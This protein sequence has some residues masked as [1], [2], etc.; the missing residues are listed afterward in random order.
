[1]D[2]E[3]YYIK[4]RNLKMYKTILSITLLLF[5]LSIGL[6]GNPGAPA[7]RQQT[8]KIQ[9]NPRLVVKPQLIRIERPVLTIDNKPD[10]D[11]RPEIAALGIPVRP[12]QGA[13]G[14]CSVF[15]M[16]FLLDFMYAKH[17]GFTNADFSEE[18]LNYVSNLAIGQQVD[19]GFFDQLDK[20]YQKYGIVN[21]SLAPYKSSFDPNMKLRDTVL[22]TGSAIAP[23]L[24]QH[25]IKAWDVNTGLQASQLLAILFQLKQG[26]PVAA[27]LRWPKEGKFATEKILG[28][29]LMK[30]PPPG[31]VFDGHSID[32]VGYKASKSFPGE[33]YL[34]FR[35]S[36]GTGFGDN[37]YGYMSFDYA[38][39]Y[40]ND[41]IEYTKP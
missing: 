8:G 36:W 6:A 19:G 7:S 29:T 18:Y 31:D 15:A 25:F 26:R 2:F 16:T 23:R 4:V 38:M 39:K 9:R 37:G 11:L 40:V 17:Y 30:T 3:I 28:L 27:G 21:E 41:L 20:G 1:M 34:I 24:K 14:T 5:V 13:R 22:K 32:F 35:N 10:V 33:G 12:N